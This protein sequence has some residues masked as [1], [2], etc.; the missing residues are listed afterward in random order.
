MF[1]IINEISDKLFV[2]DVYFFVFKER[3][4]IKKI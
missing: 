4:K 1:R 2:D 3:E